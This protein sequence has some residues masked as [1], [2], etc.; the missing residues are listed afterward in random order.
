MSIAETAVQTPIRGVAFDLDGLMVN[1]EVIFNEVGREILRRRDREMTHELVGLMMGRRAPEAIGNMIAFHKLTDSVEALI[2]E[3]RTLFFELLGT[4][5]EPM[6]GLFELLDHIE[7][8][9]IPK[10]V[11]TSSERNYLEDVLTR[12]NILDRFQT[13]LAAED[14]TH[15]K[16]EPEIYLTAARRLGVDPHE[17]MVL[18]DSHAGTTAGVRAGAVVVSVPH[19]HSRLF[20]LSHAT[21]IASQLNDPWVMRRLG[22]P[23]K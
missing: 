13:T 4:R 2:L 15:G 19:E 9:G 1:T 12:L 20:D 22:T 7:A 10:A 17:L 21:Y 5:L 6:P 3:T 16:P 14:V 11:A 23:S 8:C 18:E